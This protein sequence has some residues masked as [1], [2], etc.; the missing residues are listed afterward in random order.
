MGDTVK[1]GFDNSKYFKLD[2]LTVEEQLEILPKTLQ[3][4]LRTLIPRRAADR[5]PKIAFLGQCLMG[6]VS[7]HYLPPLHV[8][9][10][11]TV[12]GKTGSQFL[13]NVL[14]KLGVSASANQTRNFE[15]SA[16]VG[17][18]F[19]S[20]TMRDQLEMESPL[21]SA[22]NVDIQK[23]TLTGVGTFHGTGM[24]FSH[25]SS[26]PFPSEVITRRKVTRDEILKHAVAI[27]YYPRDKLKTLRTI[28]LKGQ[29]DA[30][31]LLKQTSSPIDYLRVSFSYLNSQTLVPQMS[32]TMNVIT[33]SNAFPGKHNVEFLPLIDLPSTDINCIYTTLDFLQN[34]HKKLSAPSKDISSGW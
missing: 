7:S 21:F 25:I 9:V 3:T 10:G 14:S 1:T 20:A 18:T 16:A 8:M 6:L 2:E 5:S 4:F 29:M 34:Q 11:T 22:D 26:Q 19:G 23:A 27:K 24:I 12:H 17:E 32:G 15:R 33:R 31:S 28:T 13:I 30:T